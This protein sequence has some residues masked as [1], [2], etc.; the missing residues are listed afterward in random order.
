MSEEQPGKPKSQIFALKTTTGQ[1]VNVANLLSNRATSAKLPVFSVMV[2][3]ALKGYIFVEAAGPHFVDEAASGIKHA[4][5]RVQ[6]LV[7]LEELERYVVSKPMV[8]ELGLND[9]VELAAGPLKGMKAKITKIDKSKNEVTLELLESTVTLP[10]T[11][12]ADYVRLIS[13]AGGGG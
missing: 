1:E 3:D 7:K 8:E 2:P 6:G 5:Q 9:T 13:R 4:R 10:I 11:V 12:H